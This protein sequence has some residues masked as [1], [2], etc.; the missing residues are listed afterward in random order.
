MTIDA[1]ARRAGM[2]VRNLRAHRSRGL[3]PPP[4]MHGRT[5]YYGP[6]HLARLR[7][8]SDM[9][10]GGFN[11]S[12]IKSLLDAAPPGTA[13]EVLAFERALMTPWGP[14]GP[15]TLDPEELLAAFGNPSPKI[16]ERSV[17][18]GLL[19][20]RDDGRVEVP[21]P[22]LIRAGRELAAAGVPPE[23]MIETLEALLRHARGIASS[24][25]DLFLD[26]VWR[27]FEARGER[28]EEWPQVRRA[29]ERL[30]P[31]AT[32]ALAAAFATTM[33]AAVE[34]AFGREMQRP[35]RAGRDAG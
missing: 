21:V 16:V 11:L 27:P 1:L 4:E 33:K 32:E 23:R 20:L 26:G 17:A 10:A 34:E 30:R 8:I 15:E 29:I 35:E 9:Q 7:L 28:A 13:E 14:E 5:G 2:T 3:L 19:K 31:V 22:A 6:E 12:A 25:V 18:L 24:F